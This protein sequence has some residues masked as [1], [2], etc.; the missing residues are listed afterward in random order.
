MSER[1]EATLVITLCWM[2]CGLT[3][4]TALAESG[5]SD[6]EAPAE[7]CFNNARYTGTC[8]VQPAEEE[9]C[10]SILDYLNNPSSSGKSYCS[11]TEIRGG[12]KEIACP[13]ESARWSVSVPIQFPDRVGTGPFHDT[14][15]DQTH[16]EAYPECWN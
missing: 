9:S 10:A 1:R 14:A 4:G 2:V 15:S 5:R 12:W 16:E 7:C 13:E 6:S 8:V 3:A 11:F